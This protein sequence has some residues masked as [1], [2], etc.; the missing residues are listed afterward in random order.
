MVSWQCPVPPCSVCPVLQPHPA[1]D[2]PDSLQRQPECTGRS[3]GCPG[4]R[5][6]WWRHRQGD[7]EILYYS[8]P[9]FA[10]LQAAQALVGTGGDTGKETVRFCTN[11]CPFL[12]LFRPPRRLWA[13][14]ATPARRRWDF[15]LL[16]LR[17]FCRSSGRPGVRGHRWR[18]RQGDS[19]ILYYLLFASFATLQAVQALVGTNGDAGKETVRLCTTTCPFCR[20]SGRPGV[21]GTSGDTSKKT[22]RFCTT[23][24]PFCRSSGRPGVRGTSGDTSKETV[25]C[26]TTPCPFCRSSG[27]P[28]VRGT[29]GTLAAFSIRI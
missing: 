26:C 12:P 4:A 16:Y 5:G 9:L 21:R 28:G 24:C 11:L 15:V 20:S 7:G 2:R 29:S 10:A 3:S 17:S 22:V 19:E 18:H 6:H 25:R 8:L 27:R 14:V 13:P 1:Q 23:P